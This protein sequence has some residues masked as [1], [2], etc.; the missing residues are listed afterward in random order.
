MVIS[1][2]YGTVNYKRKKLTLNSNITFDG[3]SYT[4]YS[5]VPDYMTIPM[6]YKKEGVNGGNETVYADGNSAYS[7]AKIR[8]ADSKYYIPYISDATNNVA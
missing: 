2:T 8:L 3:N 7:G 5:S 4:V 1:H 6:G